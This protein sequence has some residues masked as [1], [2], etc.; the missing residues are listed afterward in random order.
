MMRLTLF[1]ALLISTSVYSASTIEIFAAN[2]LLSDQGQQYFD[3]DELKRA[4]KASVE[5]YNVQ[6]LENAELR[7]SQGLPADAKEAEKIARKRM[8]SKE[9][10]DDFLAIKK[11]VPGVLK[12]AT[13]QIKKIPAFVFDHE[14]IVYGTTPIDALNQYKKFKRTRQ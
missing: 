14:F 9:Y 13:Y 5:V 12:V 2:E 4:T 1:S 6:A 7:V 11:A 3:I 8:A 10:R